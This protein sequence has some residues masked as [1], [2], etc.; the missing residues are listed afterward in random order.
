MALLNGPVLYHSMNWSS[1][2]SVVLVS[3]TSGRDVKEKWGLGS[4][5]E[6]GGTSARR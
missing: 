4:H 2:V 5:N 3:V 1:F 6:K